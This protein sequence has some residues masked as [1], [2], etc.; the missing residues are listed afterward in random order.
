[1]PC[2]L[3]AQGSIPNSE[4]KTYRSP[5]CQ[6]SSPLRSQPSKAVPD[7]SKP[8]WLGIYPTDFTADSPCP[9]NQRVAVTRDEDLGGRRSRS[10]P[11]DSLLGRGNGSSL[12][13]P[14]LPGMSICC[15]LANWPDQPAGRP[16]GARERDWAEQSTQHRTHF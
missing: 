5:I 13:A 6:Y 1:M 3:E 11:R 15:F 10:S 12:P 4:S 9:G 2:G 8:A 16:C 7:S 14:G